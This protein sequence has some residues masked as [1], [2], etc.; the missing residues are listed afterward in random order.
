MKKHNICLLYSIIFL[1][2]T[3]D[4]IQS[5]FDAE[6]KQKICWSVSSDI[7]DFTG[8]FSI[9]DFKGNSSET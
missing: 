9:E 2:K 8:N 1:F 6:T 7:R 4:L 3:L 5:S